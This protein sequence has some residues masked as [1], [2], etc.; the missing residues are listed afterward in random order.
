M[1]HLTTLATSFVMHVLVRPYNDKMANVVV[2]L[3][4]ATSL[5]GVFASTDP[6]I[7][8]IFVAV[9]ILSILFVVGLLLMSLR[10]YLKVQKKLAKLDDTHSTFKKHEF[11]LFETKLLFPF[12]LFVWIM[13]YLMKGLHKCF[14]LCSRKKNSP[15]NQNQEKMKEMK[16]KEEK[17]KEKKKMLL[18]PKPPVKLEAIK[19]AKNQ[20]VY[21]ISKRV[22]R[23]HGTTT[24]VTAI[25]KGKLDIEI[26]MEKSSKLYAGENVSFHASKLYSYDTDEVMEEI[27]MPPPPPPSMNSMNSM[28]AWGVEDEK[29]GKSDGKD[30]E[31]GNS[32]PP[33]PP[34]S[35]WG[36][37]EED[38]GKGMLLKEKKKKKKK[39]KNKRRNSKTKENSTKVVPININDDENNDMKVIE[40]TDLTFVPAPPV[41]ETKKQKEQSVT[42]IVK[43]KSRVRSFF[44]STK[45]VTMFKKKDGNDAK[46]EMKTETIQP[47]DKNPVSNFTIRVVHG[48]NEGKTT[49]RLLRES[50]QMYIGTD[51]EE[52]D[53]VLEGDAVS[54]EHAVICWDQEQSVLMFIDHDSDSGSKVNGKV[55]EA[56]VPVVLTNDDEIFIGESILV[57]MI[58]EPPKLRPRPKP[59]PVF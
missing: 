40:E 38:T 15:N 12:L 19:I 28:S 35:A 47:S 6:M 31:N 39:K 53:F 50:F 27:I 16:E 2:V 36:D 43:K 4:G 22:G 41:L 29:S 13:D 45:S 23:C 34:M 32:Q 20:R 33:P 58:K 21:Y 9:T 11:S 3:F 7:Q 5:V 24:G 49:N 18:Q 42:P 10:S 8:K 51:D 37:E 59:P 1:L 52:C 54:D 44:S 26:T 57:V 25:H 14:D 30:I 56:N 46:K 17:E 48:S 55:A